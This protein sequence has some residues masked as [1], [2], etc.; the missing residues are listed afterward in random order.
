M[1]NFDHTVNVLVKAYLNDE[2]EHGNCEACAVGNIV[3]AAGFPRYDNC[4]MPYDSCGMW[5]SVF[6]TDDGKQEFWEPSSR[7]YSH[8]I[9]K[10]NATGYTVDELARVEFAFETALGSN[11]DEWMFNGLMD[12]VDVLAEIHGIDLEVKESAKLLFVK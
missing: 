1:R 8:G 5:K 4:K 12:V 11:P 10:I 2:L 7:L 3:H 9:D 6:Y